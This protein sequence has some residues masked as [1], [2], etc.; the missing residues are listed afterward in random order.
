M[1]PTQLKNLVKWVIISPRY[2]KF[3]SAKIP[4]TLDSLPRLSVTFRK[5][6]SCPNDWRQNDFILLS[7]KKR[8]PTFLEKPFNHSASKEAIC[9]K[10]FFFQKKSREEFHQLPRNNEFFSKKK[11]SK[12]NSIHPSP[13]RHFRKRLKFHFVFFFFRTPCLS[14]PQP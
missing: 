4:V 13:G 12:P 7:K 2:K 8:L 11:T 6:K 9:R 1:K 14:F 5:Q 3:P 10:L